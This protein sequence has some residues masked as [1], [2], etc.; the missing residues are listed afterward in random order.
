MIILIQMRFV[1]KA[2]SEHFEE[3]WEFLLE[4]QPVQNK[5]FRAIEKLVTDLSE[6]QLSRASDK[7]KLWISE[8]QTT[9]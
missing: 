6:S 2:T 4:N 8:I 9:S 3:L 5:L 1:Q 7:L